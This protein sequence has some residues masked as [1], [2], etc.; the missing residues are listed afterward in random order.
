MKID[1]MNLNY[2]DYGNKKGKAIVL[3]HGWGQNIEMMKMLGEPFKKDFR[4]IVVDFPGFGLSPEPEEVMGIDGYTKVIEE[5][6]NKLK[7][8]EPI[9]IGHS[10]GG[11]VS[12]K[13]ASRNK[14]SKVILLSPALRGHDKKGLKTKI[15]KSLKKVPGI[16]K[17]EGWAKD[18]IGS[19]DYKAASPVMKKVLVETVNEDLSDD[20]R[21]ITAPTILIYGDYDSE[22]PEEDTKK[23]ERLISDCGLILYEGCTHWAYLERL[24]QTINIIGNFIK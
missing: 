6:L 18:H 9:L 8:K 12:V 14:V 19:R 17:L 5:L 13:Y 22:V 15:L 3:L 7:I 16:N 10:F 23:Y 11:R 1:N 2:L 20:A 24:E 21:K 4:I